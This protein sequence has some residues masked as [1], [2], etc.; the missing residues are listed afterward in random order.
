MFLWIKDAPDIETTDGLQLAPEF[1]D[2]YVSTTLP[3]DTE[4]Q[5]YQ[6]VKHLQVHHHTDTCRKNG[7]SCRFHFPKPVSTVTKLKTNVDFQYIL[8]WGILQCYRRF[9]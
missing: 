5:E 7:Q 9:T 4:S 1:I 2:K 8:Y 3:D 6:L